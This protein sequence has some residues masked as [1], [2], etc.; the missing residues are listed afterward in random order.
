MT[1]FNSSSHSLG[2]SDLVGSQDQ[3]LVDTRSVT[4]NTFTASSVSECTP[5]IG[6]NNSNGEQEHRFSDIRQE[7]RLLL[8]YAIPIFGTQMLE[9]SLMIAS[10]ISI[11]HI[12]TEALAASTLGSMTA[13]VSGLSIIHGFASALDS[14][15]PQAWTSG[16]PQHVG[17]WTQRMMLLMSV[18][19]IPILAIWLNAE[20]ILLR[21]KQEP[22]IAHL[23]G[24]Y[25]RW[26]SLSLPG[27]AVSIVL[28]R[29]YQAQGLMH[30]PTLIMVIIAPI[31]ALLCWVL[32]WG[33]KPLNTGFIGAPIAS[34][35]SFNL[36]AIILIVYAKWFIPQTAS[37]PV[38]R[39][40]FQEIGRLFRLG[41]SGTGQIASEWWSWE[42][43]ALAASQLGPTALAAQSVLLVSSTIAF[44]TPY[45][46]G[47]ATT[48]R[49]GNL[50]GSGYAQKAK[51]AAETSIGMSLVTAL[52]L[53]TIFMLFRT[54]WGRLFNND[55]TVVELVSSVLPLVA[56]F[57]IVDGAT[58]VTDGV[59]RARGMLGFGAIVN[60]CSYYV[61]GL[62]MGIIL[63]FWANLGL[64]G[65]WT[66]LAS[67]LFCAATISIYVVYKT[68]WDREVSKAHEGLVGDNEGPA[69]V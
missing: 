22:V 7:S 31:N 46:L 10:V 62:P 39:K 66:G 60:I 48:V 24:V 21:L 52:I 19:L 44:Q 65:L 35:I 15:L 23:A 33:P 51:L 13:S 63:A 26:F 37:H 34:S 8:D 53:S 3:T 56:L 11:G 28:R 67:A 16:R 36:M 38:N 61:V 42:F 29:F 59:L 40:S 18:I 50:L 27:Q 69:G 2:T 45:S 4:P 58:A 12:S 47:I 25:L 41:L 55:E 54:S 6:S 14:L 30:I 20:W 64:K 9:Y 5:L 49:V 32:V 1:S 17:L 57:Q 68:D 43:V